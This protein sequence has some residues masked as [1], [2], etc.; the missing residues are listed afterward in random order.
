MR[1][2]AVGLVV[3]LVGLVL[4][5]TASAAPPSCPVD[6]SFS[7]EN[8]HELTL[9]GA[10]VDPDPGDTVTYSIV[11]NTGPAHGSLIGT[12]SSSVIYRPFAGYAGPDGFDYTASDGNSPPVQVH[13][14][15][16]VTAPAGAG[17]LP[18]NCPQSSVF[19]QANTTVHLASACTDPEGQPLNV[20]GF[21]PPSH[22]TFTPTGPS[23]ADYTPATDYT[24][25]DGFDFTV[26]D[27]FLTTTSFVSL[28]VVPA[29]FGGP[30]ATA[31]EATPAKP[32]V[33]GLTLPAG[34]V[35]NVLVQATPQPAA[36]PAGFFTFG[37]AFNVVAPDGDAANPLVLTFTVDG[38]QAPSGE[39]VVFRNGQPIEDPCTGAGATPDPCIVPADR[40]DP[41]QDYT[42]TVRSSHASLWSLGVHRPY[43]FTGLFDPVSNSPSVSTGQA[44]RTYPVSFGAGGDQGLDVLLTGSPSSRQASC[45]TGAPLSA[46]SPTDSAGGGL[47]YDPLTQRYQYNWRT[48][49]AWAGTCRTLLVRLDDGSVHEARFRFKG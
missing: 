44:G 7:V 20:V 1:R 22:G 32:L 10:C 9:T 27:G 42:V 8:G 31:A 39:L 14:S 43:D 47:S 12:S 2:V 21:H 4:V 40:P 38:S 49:K 46:E 35:G 28:H 37:T 29:G 45:D 3:G 33:A 19:V 11:P 36:P 17:G 6:P 34:V 5:P 30:F 26:S 24:G 13:V 25:D 23:Q 18:P 41:G 48:S 16:T 15:I